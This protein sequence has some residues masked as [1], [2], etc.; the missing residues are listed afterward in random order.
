MEYS[1]LFLLFC[2]GCRR[3]LPGLTRSRFQETCFL[4][5]TS[6]S[7]IC[8]HLFCQNLP[9]WREWNKTS[10]TCLWGA[11]HS[12][13]SLTCFRAWSFEA[14]PQW[15]QFDMLQGFRFWSLP[16]VNPV[17]HASGLK[18]K[19]AH[20]G[21]VRASSFEACPQW[22]Q[23]GMLKGFT[24]LSPP[25]RRP[26]WHALT[27]SSGLQIWKPPISGHVWVWRFA[28]S[29]VWFPACSCFPVRTYMNTCVCAVSVLCHSGCCS[30]CQWMRNWG[31]CTVWALTLF[32]TRRSKNAS[33]CDGQCL[34]Y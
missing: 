12:E 30:V 34:A 3:F 23:F 5:L 14:H 32:L 9:S 17:W 7:D 24:F 20:S 19:P 29:R 4:L 27:A 31:A 11:A 26:V 28:H 25:T 13:A 8:I 33:R 21:A 16:T 18:L 6:V 1:Q 10:D 22:S 2:A 15:S